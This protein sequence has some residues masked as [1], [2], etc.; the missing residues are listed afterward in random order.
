MTPRR[1]ALPVL[2]LA[3]MALVLAAGAHAASGTAGFSAS[4]DRTRI[5][6]ELGRTFVFRSTIANEGTATE[7]SLP[8]AMRR[9]YLPT[10]NRKS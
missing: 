8:V 1:H 4:V 6:T 2:A 5:S 9:P 7:S 3:A 10:W